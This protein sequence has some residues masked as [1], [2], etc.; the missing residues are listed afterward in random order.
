[1]T[2]KLNETDLLEKNPGAADIYR[3]NKKKLGDAAL[4]SRRPDYNLVLPYDHAPRRIEGTQTTKNIF[5]P[6][7]R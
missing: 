2:K 7:G 1:M 5:A 3:Q 4:S 6:K